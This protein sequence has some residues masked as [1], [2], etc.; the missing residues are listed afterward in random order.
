[1]FEYVA[2][3]VMDAGGFTRQLNS[4]VKDGWELENSGMMR[5]N[6]HYTTWWA[7]MR[8]PVELGD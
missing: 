7:I 1:M 5:K 6:D 8:K 4:K 2:F 3:E